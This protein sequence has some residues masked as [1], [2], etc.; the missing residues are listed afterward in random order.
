[1][2][3]PCVRQWL[4]RWPCFCGCL[5]WRTPPTVAQDPV[6]L[7][8]SVYLSYTTIGRLPPTIHFWYLSQTCHFLG[9]WAIYS[10]LVSLAGSWSATLQAHAL[11]A[12]SLD[13]PAIACWFCRELSSALLGPPVVGLGALERYPSLVDTPSLVECDLSVSAGR[14]S[15]A[16]QRLAHPAL[17]VRGQHRQLE[18][19]PHPSAQLQLL[20]L[21]VHWLECLAWDVLQSQGYCCTAL[22]YHSR[23][24]FD[25]YQSRQ[26][27]DVARPGAPAAVHAPPFHLLSHPLNPQAYKI[28]NHQLRVALLLQREPTDTASD[29]SPPQSRA[30][31]ARLPPPR[32]GTCSPSAF[33]GAGGFSGAP[34][35]HAR[36]RPQRASPGEVGALAHVGAGVQEVYV[37]QQRQQQQ[38]RL[39][40]GQDR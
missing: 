6:P 14:H 36:P 40:P 38:Q 17:K 13:S 35:G 2:N 9:A 30:Q 8:P 26:A 15:L 23:L 3:A 25:L 24:A 4:C 21:H 33:A 22:V 28:L 1:M 5:N 37:K 29:G 39:L 12:C 7:I 20:L 27:S 11:A 19:A 32:S 10:S 34:G 16:L 18:A 31:A